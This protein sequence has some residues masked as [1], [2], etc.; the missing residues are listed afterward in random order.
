MWHD[1]WHVACGMIYFHTL[2]KA[3]MSFLKKESIIRPF[4]NLSSK[5]PEYFYGHDC[6]CHKKG[7][8]IKRHVKHLK[9]NFV[10]TSRE[11]FFKATGRNNI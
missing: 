7:Y 5:I 3:K 2:R 4:F 11:P 9:K 1:I 8:K 10:H 6:V